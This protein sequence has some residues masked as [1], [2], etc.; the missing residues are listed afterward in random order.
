MRAL[1][2]ILIALLS[3]CRSS[4]PTPPDLAT[5]DGGQRALER[6]I[7][8]EVNRVRQSHGLPPYRW[9]GALNR[10]AQLHSADMARRD[11]FDHVTPE[12]HTVQHRAD[13]LGLATHRSAGVSQ[14]YGLGE[15]LFYAHRYHRIRTVT[16]ENGTRRSTD[17]KTLAEM[18]RE[19]V[20]GWMTSPG[21]R[22]NLLHRGFREHG[23]GAAFDGQQRVFITQNL[24]TDPVA[25]R[26]DR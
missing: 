2:L 23:I 14:A 10:L 11:Y 25:P 5:A 19:S 18:A 15:N 8:E 21:H 13:R 6:A 3:G 4:A 1:C 20:D 24:T 12:G 17:W 7:H 22:S 16:D 9:S 26:R